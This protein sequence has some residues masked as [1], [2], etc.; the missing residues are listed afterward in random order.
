M[1]SYGAGLNTIQGWVANP[2][3]SSSLPFC[4]RFNVA[5]TRHAATLDTEPLAK[6]YS[7]GCS[8]RLSSNHFQNARAF[9][10]YPTPGYGFNVR[11]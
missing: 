2:G 11:V 1:L 3:L 4:L 9:Y 7:D 6:S 10:G 5:V 8:S